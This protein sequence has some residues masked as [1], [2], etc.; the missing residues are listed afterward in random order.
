MNTTI[1]ETTTEPI[2]E[3]EAAAKSQPLGVAID[4]AAY[5]I[6]AT[7]IIYVLVRGSSAFSSTATVNKVT[8]TVPTSSIVSPI[9]SVQSRGSGFFGSMF[10]D[11]SSREPVA[12]KAS[13]K[14]QTVVIEPKKLESPVLAKPKSQAKPQEDTSVPAIKKK[15]A[16]IWDVRKE[17][18][19]VVKEVHVVGETR[20]IETK[21][22]IREDQDVVQETKLQKQIREVKTS[23]ETWIQ[24]IRRVVEVE[25][26]VVGLAEKVVTGSLA[27]QQQ[28]LQ[29][30]PKQI[31]VIESIPAESRAQVLDSRV[32][33]GW[34]SNEVSADNL[35]SACSH[36][37]KLR[38]AVVVGKSKTAQLILD[39]IEEN[40]GCDGVSGASNPIQDER[41]P[42]K[43]VK[44][45]S[46]F[47]TEGEWM[48]GEEK[49]DTA[50][51]VAQKTFEPLVEYGRAWRKGVADMFVTQ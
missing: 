12:A 48:D 18:K 41:E 21:E 16:W 19:P 39:I 31:P 10:H 5:F 43:K 27:A 20:N 6:L 9:A 29:Q 8:H 22:T 1:T 33:T 26:M 45:N 23:D 46:I 28:Q 11:Q 38:Q 2:E 13:K 51:S 44:R 25:A 35:A 17:E 14:P 24:L 34:S 15:S 4:S 49:L 40:G 42:T 30:Q 36:I 37:E 47:V 3:S 32:V 7:S 50:Q